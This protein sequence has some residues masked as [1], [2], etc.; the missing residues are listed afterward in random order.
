MYEYIVLSSEEYSTDDWTSIMISSTH[1]DRDLSDFKYLLSTMREAG[2]VVGA[3]CL[4][5]R[6]RYL[7]YLRNSRI[8]VPGDNVSLGGPEAGSGF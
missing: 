1:A 5:C 2:L 6:L 4:C 3:A 7:T 8:G